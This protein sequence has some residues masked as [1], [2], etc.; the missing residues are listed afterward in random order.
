LT[1][2]N[3]VVL[4][5]LTRGRGGPERVPN[6]HVVEYYRQRAGAGLIIS[7]AASFSDEGHGW[8]ESCAIQN[9]AQVDGWRQVADAVHEAGGAIFLQLWHT[10]RASH[11]SFHADG[12]PPVAPSAITISTGHA[13]TRDGSVPHEVPRALETAEVRRIVS[14]YA[15]AAARAKRAG[16]DGVEIHAANG[17]LIDE[18]LQSKTNHRTDAYG[19]GVEQRFRFL[20]EIVEQVLEVFEADQVAVRL[21]P[22]GSFNDMGSDDFRE[23]F[24]Y[25]AKQL[26]AYK[27]AY[28]H[29]MDGL[30]FGFHEKGEPLTLRDFRSV[31][32][33]VLMGNCGYTKETASA[34]VGSGD[35]D[36]ISFG[37]PFIANP[38]LPE[39]FAND[40]PLA[41]T[42]PTDDWWFPTGAKGYTTFPPFQLSAQQ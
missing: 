32:D 20:K 23:Q 10:G 35:A 19:G 40:W 3:R 41:E 14:E 33:G 26:S 15:E 37:R 2:K 42:A 31:Y 5:P 18:F 30:A 38:D 22:N 6:E 28:L 1:L 17:Y 4:A 29:V 11:S 34:A 36:L 7:E 13:H 12:S 9:D 27:L 8:V 24:L 39:R 25:T 16:M 21:S